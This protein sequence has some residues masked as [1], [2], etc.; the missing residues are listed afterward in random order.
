MMNRRHALSLTAAG[1]IHIAGSQGKSL[2][3][4]DL[5]QGPADLLIRQAAE[6]G[7]TDLGW[8]KATTP[9]HLVAITTNGT[10]GSGRFE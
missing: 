7:H 4:D 2:A 8:L 5:S 9:F 6:R 10:W 1:L 3:G